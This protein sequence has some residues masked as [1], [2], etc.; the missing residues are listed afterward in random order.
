[1][2]RDLEQNVVELQRQFQV[3]G[4][5]A[6]LLVAADQRVRDAEQASQEATRKLREAERKLADPMM[7]RR[8]YSAGYEAARRGIA[9]ASEPAPRGVV[10]A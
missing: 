7:Y 3:F 8:G 5:L 6:H 4:D 1:M 9:K 10:A 2:T